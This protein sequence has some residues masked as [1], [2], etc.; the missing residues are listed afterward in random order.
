MRR[1][2]ALLAFLVLVP[3]ALAAQA[4]AVPMD[5]ADFLTTLSGAQNAATGFQLIP[6]NDHDDCPEGQLCCY[7]CGIDG[8]DFI[9]MDPDRR[10]RCPIIP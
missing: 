5:L 9:C 2:V 8:C 1:P 4:P 6:C 7:P 3:C 10:G